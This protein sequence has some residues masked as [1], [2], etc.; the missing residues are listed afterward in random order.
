M[1]FQR[2]KCAIKMFY[3]QKK[4]KNTTKRLGVN[5]KI[6]RQ[7]SRLAEQKSNDPF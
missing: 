2:F 7:K 5:K 3:N 1:D 6:H 4:K